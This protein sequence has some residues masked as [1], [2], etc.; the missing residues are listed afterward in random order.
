MIVC[1]AAECFPEIPQEDILPLLVDL[2]FSSVEIPLHEDGLTW[3]RPSQVLANFDKAV[4]ICR[5]T[6]RL[7]ISA[8]SV[9]PGPWGGD[10]YARFD[11]CCKLAKALRVVPLIVPAAELGTPF[12]EEIERLRE[13]VRLASLEGCLVALKTEI[14]CM[15]E[16]PDTAVVLCDN[17]KGLGLSLDPSHFVAGPRQ[18]RDYSKVMP[19]VLHVHLR[20]STKSQ[21]HVRVGQGEIDYGKL[22]LQLQQVGYDRGLSIHMPPIEGQDH[23]AEMRKMRLLLDSLL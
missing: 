19:Y 2:E 12:N 3:V 23:R 7:A 17:V 22:I 15:T 8:F 11:A 1:A 16:D 5:D 9:D 4:E 21:L 13:L 20:D 10:Y 18:G 14:G 6:S